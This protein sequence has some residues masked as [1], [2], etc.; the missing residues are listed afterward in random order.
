MLIYKS[1]S[2]YFQVC[3][4][5]LDSLFV[6][7]CNTKTWLEL[8]LDPWMLHFSI[9]SVPSWDQCAST[10][11]SLIPSHPIW[12]LRY[13]TFKLF[14]KLGMKHFHFANDF[15]T[16]MQFLSWCNLASRSFSF[17]NI[18]FLLYR[19]STWLLFSGVSSHPLSKYNCPRWSRFSFWEAWD[20][21]KELM[22]GNGWCKRKRKILV[23]FLFL[24]LL[25]IKLFISLSVTL[26]AS[27]IPH[28]GSSVHVIYKYGFTDRIPGMGRIF[29]VCVFVH[30]NINRYL[31]FIDISMIKS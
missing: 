8:R 28:A 1:P 18:F 26:A 21:N 29:P 10:N 24:S 20:G 15:L 31:L 19:K 7:L 22:P 12:S 6:A 17:F 4:F 3:P 2:H 13:K 30:H 23:S 16:F 25:N 9:H 14:W 5:S 27:S 11:V